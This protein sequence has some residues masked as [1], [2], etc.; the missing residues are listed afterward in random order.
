M[1]AE[2]S[3]S[4][5]KE[6]IADLNDKIN[7]Q[8]EEIKKEQIGNTVLVSEKLDLIIL[9]NEFVDAPNFLEKIGV[10]TSHYSRV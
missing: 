5:S 1:Q 6:N 9:E 7:A 8:M 3:D 4:N 10:D 2:G